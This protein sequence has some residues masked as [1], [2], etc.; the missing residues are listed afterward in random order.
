M[1]PNVVKI[2]VNPLAYQD[3]IAKRHRN[4]AILGRFGLF[5]SPWI[6]ALTDTPCGVSV[7]FVLRNKTKNFPHTVRG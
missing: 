7:F 6:K 2:L 4:Y 5:L 3:R 1:H